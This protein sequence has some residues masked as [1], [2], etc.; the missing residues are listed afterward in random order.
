M[1]ASSLIILT[2]STQFILPGSSHFS[3]FLPRKMRCKAPA[4][5]Y[6]EIAA[7]IWL[8]PGFSPS[9]PHQLQRGAADAGRP[10]L[11]CK[12]QI[13]LW[14]AAALAL[15]SLLVAPSTGAHAG[16]VPQGKYWLLPFM[17]CLRVVPWTCS[18]WTVSLHFPAIPSS[19]QNAL[20][21]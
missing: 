13:L 18:Y 10:V 20:G 1:S 8:I 14:Q 11:L 16:R 15:S 9:F 6:S 21:P 3:S 12:P 19:Y 4:L 7:A 2:V 17:N 5:A